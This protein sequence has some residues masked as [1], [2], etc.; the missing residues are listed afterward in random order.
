MNVDT[1]YNLDGSRKSYNVPIKYVGRDHMPWNL[2]AP[3][4][5]INDLTEYKV[6]TFKVNSV[7]ETSSEL[8]IKWTANFDDNGKF[9]SFTMN[10][11][12]RPKSGWHKFS[13]FGKADEYVLTADTLKVLDNINFDPDYWWISQD[14][15]NK[16]TKLMDAY[17][18]TRSGAI[19]YKATKNP[20][21]GLF[22]GDIFFRPSVERQNEPLNRTWQGLDRRAQF[23]LYIS[24]NRVVAIEDG[25]LVADSTLPVDFPFEDINVNFTHLIYHT[26]NE[27]GEVRT[28]NP[29]NAYWINFRPFADE[30]H[31]D[32][33][34]F[35]VLTSF[36][37]VKLL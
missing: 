16:L 19:I 9:P 23:D 7:V 10:T 37:N 6:G 21:S 36:P 26:W 34:G 2:P 32:N 14:S 5:K 33:M 11:G 30:R 8:D 1:G 22:E 24:K 17:C 15:K 4:R 25:Y 13:D 3:Y 29:D 12:A 20:T 18:I 27:I 28:W 35:E 31:W